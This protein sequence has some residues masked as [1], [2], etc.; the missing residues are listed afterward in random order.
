[1][2]LTLSAGEALRNS[3]IAYLQGGDDPDAYS[4]VHYRQLLQNTI[5][6]AA[7]DAALDWARPRGQSQQKSFRIHL[8]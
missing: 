4:S 2:D 5:N 3:P 1:M 8:R 6:W 7:S